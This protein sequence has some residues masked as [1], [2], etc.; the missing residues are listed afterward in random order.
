MQ[1]FVQFS[2]KVLP[3]PTIENWRRPTVFVCGQLCTQMAT[4]H[5]SRI[6]LRS[7]S[8]HRN[9]RILDS[10]TSTKVRVYENI[11]RKIRITVP[12]MKDTLIPILDTNTDC[13]ELKILLRLI[14]MVITYRRYRYGENIGFRSGAQIRNR[15]YPFFGVL[16]ETYP[17]IIRR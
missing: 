8:A 17:I 12:I 2:K 10:S 5:L 7:S 4:S 15:K 3:I 16:Q 11:S 1:K 14:I 6:T 9:C 13:Y